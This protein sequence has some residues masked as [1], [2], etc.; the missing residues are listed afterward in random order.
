MPNIIDQIQQVG[1]ECGTAYAI[2]QLVAA[3]T[4]PTLKDRHRCE[5]RWQ[6]WLDRRGL[7]TLS[8]LEEDL[9]RLGYQ[10]T[11]EKSKEN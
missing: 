8:L 5:G 3:E 9:K 2:S 1:R 11:I 10:L 6:R 7:K 4:D